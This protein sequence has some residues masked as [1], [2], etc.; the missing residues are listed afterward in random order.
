MNNNEYI[1]K[2]KERKEKRENNTNNAEGFQK[3]V[4]NW[5]ISTDAKPYLNPYEIRKIEK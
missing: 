3:N 2:R 5:D 1:S 4:I